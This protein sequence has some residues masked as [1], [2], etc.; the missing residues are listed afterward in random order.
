MTGRTHQIRGQMSQLGFPLCGDVMYGGSLIIPPHHQ[1]DG[2]LNSEFL[3]LQ[4]CE[5]SFRSPCSPFES[6]EQNKFRLDTSWWSAWLEEYSN[7][8]SEDQIEATTNSLDKSK[9]VKQL[10]VMEMGNPKTNVSGCTTPFVQLSP[11]KNKYVVI[12]AGK[13]SMPETEWYIRSSSPIE[14]GGPY[15]A[16]VARSL[17]EDLKQ[18]N[19][20]VVIMGGGRIDFSE[21]DKHAHVYGFSYGFGK[22]DHEFVS[23]LIEKHSEYS[24]SFDESDSLY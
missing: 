11:G 24:A 18:K 21:K 3:S 19:Y 17:V 2:F 23:M 9:E 4:C 20:D 10:Q 7:A 13:T 15:H 16:D 22:G 5:L 1:S 8:Q 14:C 6:K 12:K